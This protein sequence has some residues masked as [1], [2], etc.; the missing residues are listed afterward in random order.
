VVKKGSE[1][2]GPGAK[3]VIVAWE[4]ADGSVSAGARR[5]SP[6]IRN[7]KCNPAGWHLAIMNVKILF[8][9]Y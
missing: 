1:K 5:P 2:D 9:S 3:V 8:R 6:Q 4:V 7:Y